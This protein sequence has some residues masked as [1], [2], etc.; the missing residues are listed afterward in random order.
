[1]TPEEIK[2]MMEE[3]QKDPNKII[4]ELVKKNLLFVRFYLNKN[5]N[6]ISINVLS[7][8]ECCEFFKNFKYSGVFISSINLKNINNTNK[9]FYFYKTL[10]KFLKIY[11]EV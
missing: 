6:F 11:N 3:N 2:Q 10:K 9:I 1:M 5:Y 8:I 7:E 4:N